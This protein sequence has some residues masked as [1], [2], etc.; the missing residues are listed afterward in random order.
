M[1][2][3]DFGSEL[4]DTCITSHSVLVCFSGLYEFEQPYGIIVMIVGGEGKRNAVLN[5]L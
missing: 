1:G 3:T 2:R 4:R 5:A